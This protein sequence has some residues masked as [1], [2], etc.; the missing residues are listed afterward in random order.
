MVPRRLSSRPRHEDVAVDRSAGHFCITRTAMK[1]RSECAGPP[2]RDVY[3]SIA[4]AMATFREP[5]PAMTADRQGQNGSLPGRTD[6]ITAWPS[7][8]MIQAPSAQIRFRTARLPPRERNRRQ[9]HRTMAFQLSKSFIRRIAVRSRF[10]SLCRAPSGALQSFQL[11]PAEL[12]PSQTF[13]IRRART[14]L[15]GMYNPEL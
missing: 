8:V 1:L 3:G 13:T 10:L 4:G 12:F 7:R 9:G 14:H 15:T 5:Q 6:E 2:M 11:S